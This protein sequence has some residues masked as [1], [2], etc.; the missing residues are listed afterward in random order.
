MKNI[1]AID[2][3]IG[4]GY[5]WNQGDNL[6]ACKF[7]GTLHHNKYL[8]NIQ[9]DEIYLEKATSSSQMGVTSAFTFGQ[10]YGEWQGAI[11]RGGRV[12][13]ILPPQQWIR[14]FKD[15]IA[16]SEPPRPVKGLSESAAKFYQ[17]VKQHN[18]EIAKARFPH[19]RVTAA[20]CDALLIHQYAQQ[21]HN[22]A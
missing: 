19:L 11:M 13:T 6:F 17:R 21:K 8:S 20:T 5:A 10:N 1:L 3:G 14:W 22:N 9:L 4:G 18:R 15:S 12:P 2:T 7:E 16:D